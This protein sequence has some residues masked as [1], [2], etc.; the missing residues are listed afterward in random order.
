MT[1]TGIRVRF[2]EGLYSSTQQA[3]GFHASDGTYLRAD[4]LVGQV[5]NIGT[6][7]GLVYE[8]VRVT[9]F[10]EERLGSVLTVAGGLRGSAYG[11]GEPRPVASDD[12]DLWDIA[13][14]YVH[15]LPAAAGLGAGHLEQGEEA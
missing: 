1:A 6:K 12:I 15:K 5:V 9:G 14:G 10:R 7:D 11:G 3:W 4:S 13:R 8:A 2:S